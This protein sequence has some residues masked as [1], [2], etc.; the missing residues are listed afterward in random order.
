[1]NQH[2]EMCACNERS[3]SKIK[4][5]PTNIDLYRHGCSTNAESPNCQLRK[6]GYK[7]VYPES[8]ILKLLSLTTPQNLAG[9][10]ESQA[11]DRISFRISDSEAKVKS[12]VLILY[13]FHKYFVRTCL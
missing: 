10:P 6:L 8:S 11:G 3:V 7:L 4:P 2:N 9:R 5:A 13:Q 12:T 1:M